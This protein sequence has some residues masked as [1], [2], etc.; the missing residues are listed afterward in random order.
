MGVHQKGERF[1]N[2]TMA[3]VLRKDQRRTREY[4]VEIQK[5]WGCRRDTLELGWAVG[6]CRTDAHGVRIWASVLI[7][8][9]KLLLV[10][11]LSSCP[12]TVSTGYHLLLQICK[13]TDT[14]QR[15]SLL[16]I[17]A[18]TLK[19]TDQPSLQQGRVNEETESREDTL[20]SIGAPCI[21]TKTLWCVIDR[22]IDL[23]QWSLLT[24]HLRPK[25]AS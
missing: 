10:E 20:R 18:K 23:I 5:K 8:N 9:F 12:M 19:H 11:P 15:Y 22:N 14:P 1:E 4:P 7:L 6:I 24:Q 16:L 17:T 2:I 13:E 21:W 3:T 25:C